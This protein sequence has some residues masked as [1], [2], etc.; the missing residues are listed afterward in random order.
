VVLTW[1][2]Q[3]SVS[4]DLSPFFGFTAFSLLRVEGRDH[5]FR[6]RAPA[7]EKLAQTGTGEPDLMKIST[8]LGSTLGVLLVF[9]VISYTQ[10]L[11]LK[12]DPK[13]EVQPQRTLDVAGQIP[14]AEVSSPTSP[15]NLKTEAVQ[16]TT[17]SQTYMATAY[18]LS[19]R[20][21]SGRVV[22]RGL[23]AADP[24]VLPLG[25]RV[26]VEA[27]LWS[28]EYLVA[29][30][31]GAVKGRRIDIWTPTSREA[32]RFG[33]RTVKVAVLSFPHK[34]G[35]EASTRPRLVKPTTTSI[36]ST[37]EVVT[38]QEK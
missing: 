32:R 2:F 13:P 22:S 12:Q 30:T 27:G 18:S 14:E 34:R 4:T 17:A 25:T 35:Q 9:S 23:I 6:A 31:G 21:A 1:S 7:A 26:R 37:A 5:A 36:Q 11:I 33:R 16:P 19:G 29:D 10:T 3:R 15:T 20:T 28:G 8:L 24:H 38:K